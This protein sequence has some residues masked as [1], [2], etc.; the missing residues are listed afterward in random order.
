VD[1][2][3][4]EKSKNNIFYDLTPFFYSVEEFINHQKWDSIKLELKDEKTLI[5]FINRYFYCFK[6]FMVK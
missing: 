6:Y 4:K 1:N 2:N 5:D 3:E